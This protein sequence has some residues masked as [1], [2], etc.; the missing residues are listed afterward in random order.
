M[1]QVRMFTG[2]LIGLISRK[3]EPNLEE[4]PCRIVYKRYR[5]AIPWRL[6]DGLF[7]APG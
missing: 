7:A 2:W 6:Y 4:Q 5:F 3:D 1:E